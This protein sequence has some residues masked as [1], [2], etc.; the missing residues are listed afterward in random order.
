[1]GGKLD[2]LPGLLRTVGST[3]ATIIGI[4][5]F[6]LSIVPGIVQVRPYCHFTIPIICGS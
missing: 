3:T 6:L 2:S 4:D 5:E 1:M